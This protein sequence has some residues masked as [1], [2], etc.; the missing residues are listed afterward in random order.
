MYLSSLTPNSAIYF[1][2]CSDFGSYYE[3]IQMNVTITGYYTF[4]INSTMNTP[5]AYIYTNNFNPF[6][7]SNNVL[8]HNGDSRNQRQAELTAVLEANM[9]YVFIMTTSSSN[10]TGNVS[11][12]VFGP[13]YI[14]FNRICEY[15]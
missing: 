12:Q 3:E 2:D 8:N 13:S 11:I 6:D 10:V 9:K 15:L 14:D 5:Y 7:V 4:L 1:Q